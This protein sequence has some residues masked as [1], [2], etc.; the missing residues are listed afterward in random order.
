[1]KILITGNMGYIGPCVVQRLR[2]SYPQATLVG[3]DTGYFAHCLT[4]VDVLPECRVDI[5]YFADVRRIPKEALCDVDA[6]V[7]LAAISNDPMGN[8]FEEVTFDI[9][10]RASVELAKEAKR[11][12]VKAFIFASSCSM[13]GLADD[14]PR[15]ESSPLNPLTAYAKS[16]AYTERE[17]QELADRRFSV[18]S[19]R[20]ATAC[21]MSERLRLDLVVN[22]FA[23]CAVTSKNISILSDGTPWRPLIHLKD[24]AKAIEWAI[25]RDCDAGGNFLAVNVGSN[26]WNYQ[27][28]ELAQAVAKVV[29][30]VTV[31]VNKDAPPD[32]RSYRV[33][34]SLYE[35]LAP[36]HQP[37]V[38]L[39]TAIRELKD[40][41]DA[42]EFDDANFRSSKHMR[43]KVLMQL[44][45]R[46]LLDKN[47]NWSNWQ[48]ACGASETESL[49]RINNV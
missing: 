31:S 20:F 21:G 34:F 45:E 39:L 14:T 38:D 33:D 12:G 6:I 40:G 24:M 42:M 4:N 3:L 43:L 23:A 9:N 7:H 48:Q 32:Q 25:S 22:D 19:L 35:K 29:P 47:L 15:K 8:T 18:T 16:K 30:D 44:R 28:K 26:A 41:L 36:K 17:L 5:Q 37:L 46:G 11:Q 27:V 13:Y 1:M 10:H 49:G 2:E